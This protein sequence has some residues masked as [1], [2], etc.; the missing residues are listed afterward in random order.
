MT[1]PLLNRLRYHVTGA[2]ERG[3]KQAIVEIPAARYPTLTLEQFAALDEYARQHG[4]RWKAKLADDWMYAR[5]EGALQVLRNSHGPSWL[6]GFVFLAAAKSML[7][8]VDVTINPCP[9]FEWRVNLLNGTEATASYH[10]DIADAVATGLHMALHR[11]FE[12]IKADLAK[13]AKT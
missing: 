11:D 10:T 2:I 13:K 8:A 1:N 6:K 3:E 7:R 5:T 4:R 9:G 12:K